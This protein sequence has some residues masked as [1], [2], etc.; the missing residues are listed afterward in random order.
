MFIAPQHHEFC[1]V[2]NE[3]LQKVVAVGEHF[4]D[5][6][7]GFEHGFVAG[8]MP[9]DGEFARPGELGVIGVDLELRRRRHH[10]RQLLQPMIAPVLR[11]AEIEGG[12]NEFV[13][14]RIVNFQLLTR[15]NGTVVP[16]IE[17]V[18]V[19][20]GLRNFRPVFGLV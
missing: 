17:P 6:I 18:I 5:G 15:A 8:L 11:R 9:Y 10:V 20:V 16:I 4:A 14:D 2:T 19:E 7:V 13:T 1:A 12:A 3:C